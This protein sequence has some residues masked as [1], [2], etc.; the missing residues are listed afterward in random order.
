[1]MT[2]LAR[3]PPLDDG[4]CDARVGTISGRHGGLLA[5]TSRELAREIGIEISPIAM[6]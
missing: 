1:M 2:A 5:D 6:M 3:R 4:A